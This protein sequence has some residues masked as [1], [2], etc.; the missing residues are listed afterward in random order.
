MARYPRLSAQGRLES[1][2]R[3]RQGPEHYRIGRMRSRAVHSRTADE[4]RAD[5]G[6]YPGKS[7]Y[8]YRTPLDLSAGQISKISRGFNV[9]LVPAQINHGNF[10]AF[11]T[12]TQRHRLDKAKAAG[13]GV[14]LHLTPPQLASHFRRGKGFFSD[15]GRNLGH[16]AVSTVFGSGI[17]KRRG[18]NVLHTAW[19]YAKRAAR[20]RP[21]RRITGILGNELLDYGRQR[22]NHWSNPD[23]QQ[24][25][26][27]DQPGAPQG[28]TEEGSGFRRRR[29]RRGGSFLAAGY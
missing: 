27:I 9:Q 19:D 3:V 13:R 4:T 22:L 24:P 7:H 10:T 11:L 1:R 29:R 12:T 15:L 6:R 20:S 18:G 26:N 25:A 2:K 14:R 16:A 8:Q 5:L 17:R 23:E 21:A 28:E